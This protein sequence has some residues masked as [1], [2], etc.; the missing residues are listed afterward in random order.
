MTCV[1]GQFSVPGAW[2]LGEYLLQPTNGGAIAFFGPT[3]LSKSLEASELDVKLATYLQA[4]AMLGLGDMV[5][6][7]MADHISQDLPTVPTWIYNL[8]G[9]PALHYNIPRTLAPLQITFL[10]T[11]YLGW[12]GGVAPYQVEATTNLL[13]AASWQPVGSPLLVNQ[14][15]VTNGQPAEF[16]RVRSGQ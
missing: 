11:N 16:Y 15:L 3:G 10:T 2:C 9:D 14:M 4:N 6:Q 8:L 1:S 7:A 12:A 13:N 5:R